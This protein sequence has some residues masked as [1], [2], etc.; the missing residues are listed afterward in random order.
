MSLEGREFLLTNKRCLKRELTLISPWADKL[1]DLRRKKGAFSLAEQYLL[2]SL[3]R[4]ARKKIA[5]DEI[6]VCAIK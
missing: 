4:G 1:F 2:K 6:N 3:Q 5:M